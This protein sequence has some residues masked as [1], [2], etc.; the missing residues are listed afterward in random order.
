M[1]KSLTVRHLLTVSLSVVL[2]VATVQSTWAVTPYHDITTHWAKTEL[3]YLA[4]HGLVKGI[5]STQ[6]APDAPLKDYQ[7]RLL[8]NRIGIKVAN[9]QNQDIIDREEALR[10]CY[11]GTNLNMNLEEVSLGGFPDSN[12]IV[13][14]SEDAFKWALK[15]GYIKGDAQGLIMPQKT[16]TRAEGMVMMFRI[17]Q[18]QSNKEFSA[19]LQTVPGQSNFNLEVSWGQKSTGGYNLT[20][21]RYEMVDGILNVYV[22]ATSP[23]PDA[24]V[25]MALT[26]PK[27]TITL[28]DV[29]ITLET[30]IVVIK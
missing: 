20:I 16:L 6:L 18:D 25:T 26:Y 24:M 12:L 14:P 28:K 19:K 13:A 7:W 8:L 21:D 2:S 29:A 10:L 17:L 22:K 3:T 9:N 11:S 15:G 23:A 4:E 5:S 1:K 27:A 30:P